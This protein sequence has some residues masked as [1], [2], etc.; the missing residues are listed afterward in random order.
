MT[1]NGCMSYVIKENRKEN[2][3]YYAADCNFFFNKINVIGH[4][5][6]VDVTHGMGE[7]R[8]LLSLSCFVPCIDFSIFQLDIDVDWCRMFL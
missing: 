8:T 3:S 6:F 2:G 5:N 1:S 7:P 4:D